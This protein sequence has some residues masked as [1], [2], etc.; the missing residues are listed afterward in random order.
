ML[1]TNTPFLINLSGGKTMKCL[2]STFV[3]VAVSALGSLSFAQEGSKVVEKIQTE[4]YD[5]LDKDLTT[6]KFEKGSATL[7][8][9]ERRTL[10]AMVTAVRDD[11]KVETI[12]VAAWS[13]SQYPAK[14]GAKL[15][16]AEKKLADQRAANVKTVLTDLGVANVQVYSMAE[17]PGWI[18][19]TFRTDEAK[20][21]LS[22]NGKHVEDR[23]AEIV[24]QT[25]QS[26]GGPSS[27]VVIVKRATSVSASH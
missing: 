7:T 12:I 14:E 2:K 22:L 20:V 16:D 11:T 3:V 8:D 19:K 5:I 10:R 17:H 25:L 6:V 21:K 18:A 26:E 4:I 1:Q 9:T 27:V 24:A 23:K 15:G 13:D